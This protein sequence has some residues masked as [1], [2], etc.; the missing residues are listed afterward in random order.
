MKEYQKLYK[1][2][3]TLFAND[4]LQDS[5]PEQYAGIPYAMLPAWGEHYDDSLLKI[6][7][8]GK[9][10]RGWWG[11]LPQQLKEI[12]E[13]NFDK[14]LDM[15]EFQNLD[16]LD[17]SSRTRYTFW[18]FILYMLSAVYGV[19]NWEV[20]KRGNFVHILKSFLWGNVFA[21]ETWQSGGI[22]KKAVN[23]AAFHRAHVA[24]DKYFNDYKLIYDL[25]QPDI[26]FLLCRDPKVDHF[27]RHIDKELLPQVSPYVTMWR[28]KE[29]KL[30]IRMPHPGWF[31]YS[32]TGMRELESMV[33][34]IRRTLHENGL[35][36]RLQSFMDLGNHDE[37]VHRMIHALFAKCREIAPTTR[38]A[39]KCI[40]IELSKQNSQMTARRLFTMLNQYGYRTS[41][42]TE[43]ACG[44][45]SYR[46]VSCAYK[47]YEHKG[48]EQVCEAIAR[49]FTK[50]DGTYAY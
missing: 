4:L 24:A 14:S 29:N 10:T 35:F 38:E 43:Y 47:Y 26:T 18:G 8:I 23:Q 19:Q 45:G 49:A 20:L 46:A 17:W 5:Q 48:D 3:L 25:K 31:R 36:A 2:C 34:A 44:R 28:T 37:D 15:S 11:E 50:P 42:G 12:N 30:I 13:G 22:N 32:G 21:V 16:Y 33:E 1:E 6:A 39:I 7:F 41:Y 40:A 27:L 9:E